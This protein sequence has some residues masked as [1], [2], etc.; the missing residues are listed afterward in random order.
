MQYNTFYRKLPLIA[1]AKLPGIKSHFELAPPYRKPYDIEAVRLQNPKLAAV[2]I[3]L[4]PFKGQVAFVL[5]KRA[6]YA[7]HH[8][9]QVSF[10]GGKK[11]ASDTD[12]IHTAIR[13]TKEETGISI[14]ESNII[15][16]L[17][18]IYIPPSHFLVTPVLA[19]IDFTPGFTPNHEVAKIIK[20]PVADLLA[21]SRQKTK[22]V[23]TANNKSV[24]AP[25][26]VFNNLF[27]WGA[28]AMILNELKTIFY[29]L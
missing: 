22:K 8:A 15:R 23:L 17:T 12:L 20:V 25:G 16:P 10:P 28:T 19:F 21:S 11:E 4:F 26:F 18:E 7:G 24:P 2:M 29:K 14:S 1:Q 27:V 9:K 5:T 3:L 6:D 13:E